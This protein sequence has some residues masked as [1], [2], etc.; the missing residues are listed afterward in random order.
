MTSSAR[1]GGAVE[2]AWVGAGG[3]MLV[4]GCFTWI[5]YQGERFYTTVRLLFGD[6]VGSGAPFVQP[7]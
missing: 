5:D 7:I 3:S 4:D 1:S 2:A 6:S